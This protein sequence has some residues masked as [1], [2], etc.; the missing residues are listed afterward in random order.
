[1]ARRIRQPPES[2]STG[3]ASI[4]PEKPTRSRARCRRPSPSS[5]PARPF[6]GAE[7]PSNLR[8]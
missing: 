4:S 5:P 7:A 3:F 1:M 6:T 8:R 2:S